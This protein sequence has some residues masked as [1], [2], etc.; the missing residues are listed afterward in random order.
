M[1]KTDRKPIQLTQ[2]QLENLDHIDEMELS[3]EKLQR[4][5]QRLP[6]LLFVATFLGSLL[7]IVADLS[8]ASGLAGPILQ[9]VNP[10]PEV[11]VAGSNTILGEGITMASE[12]QQEFEKQ[13]QWTVQIPLMG[14]VE[15]TVDAQVDGIG[16][17]RG[18]EEA[19][20]GQ[21]NLLA[22][23]EPLPEEEYQRLQQA[24]V[25]VQCAAE[26]GYDIITFI[27]DINNQVGEIS[28]RD[29]G[30][31]LSG[32]ITDWSQVGG[33]PGPIYILVR[34]GSG[35]TEL[36]LKK[37]TGSG[38]YR[39][40]FI[41][42][43][44]N[45]ECLDT[46]LSLPGSL[47]WVSVAWLRTQ[48]PRYLRLIL[49]QRGNL[50]PEDPLKEAAEDESDFDPDKYTV[51]LIRPLYMYV[52]SGDQLDDKSTQLAREFLSYVRG[53]RGQEILESHHFYTYFDPPANVQLD[54][55]PGFERDPNGVPVVCRP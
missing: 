31:I 52:L 51:E 50:P 41:E 17:V 35:T 55:P 33:P 5:G 45:S 30:S 3:L 38:E 25:E 27:T 1:N 29:M 47:Y 36:V 37:F 23:S 54:L 48:P 10:V 28:T 18:F 19:I 39:P 49:V 42:C 26:I 9:F 2:E 8:D 15:R 24:G 32:S 21:V 7:G 43:N 22:A 16:S 20:Q 53:V 46:A 13:K 44:S 34:P 40:H 11:R 6:L 14:K 12:W 4:S